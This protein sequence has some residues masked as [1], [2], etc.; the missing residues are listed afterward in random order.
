V[1]TPQVA[2][3]SDFVCEGCQAW[4]KDLA[5]HCEIVDA[6]RRAIRQ[7]LD[8]MVVEGGEGGEE[9]I[10]GFTTEETIMSVQEMAAL[11]GRMAQVTERALAAGKGVT[12]RVEVEV[13]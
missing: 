12:A 13:R 6:R 3:A 5:H 11:T 10:V 2:E 9:V 7:K 8:E 1:E 4:L